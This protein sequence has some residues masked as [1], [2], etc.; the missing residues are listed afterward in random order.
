M[1]LQ[2]VQRQALF[3]YIN[4]H[5]LI[6]VT[7]VSSSATYEAFQMRLTNAKMNQMSLIA[8]WVS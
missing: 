5:K 2:Y 8:G 6:V 4:Y 1:W 3:F 7:T